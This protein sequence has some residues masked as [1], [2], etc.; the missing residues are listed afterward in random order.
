MHH[1]DADRA[2]GMPSVVPGKRGAAERR[3]GTYN[4]SLLR[5]QWVLC[6]MT[7]ACG[8]GSPLPARNCA[9]GGDDTE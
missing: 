9:L 8:Y 5:W 7:P 1:P 3:P 2:A 4:H 6:T